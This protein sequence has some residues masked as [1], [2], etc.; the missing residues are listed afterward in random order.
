MNKNLLVFMFISLIIGISSIQ[1]LNDSTAELGFMNLFLSPDAR[2]TSLGG[3][4]FPNATGIEAAFF[5]PAGCAKYQDKH[6]MIFS[7]SKNNNTL[8]FINFAAGPFKKFCYRANFL[9]GP[10]LSGFGTIIFGTVG[11]SYSFNYKEIFIG[12]SMDYV[13][14]DIF[15]DFSQGFGLSCGFQYKLLKILDLGLVVRNAGSTLG[16]EKKSSVFPFLISAG[17]GY[18]YQIY[19]NEINTL[20][21]MDMLNKNNPS[22]D[23]GI[24][25]GYSQ[26]IF[27]RTGFNVQQLQGSNDFNMG[28]FSIGLGAKYNSIGLDLAWIPSS[29]NNK[30]IEFSFKFDI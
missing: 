28:Q 3:A 12:L 7:Y 8:D 13:F 1:A 20:I 4:L 16:N 24:E 14:S 2:N 10:E 27:L 21:S 25:Y 19:R 23:F 22:W 5:N 15:H 26:Y 29:D 6:S 17:I 9:K 30:N 18:Q 11:T